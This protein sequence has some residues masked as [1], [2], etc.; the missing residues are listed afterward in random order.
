M[1]K[2]NKSN[3]SM[4]IGT[5]TS[6][7]K[8]TRSET[9]N[10][11]LWHDPFIH[12]IL[13]LFT[14]FAVY[15]NSINVPFMFDD[16]DFLVKNPVIKS[17]DCFP[18]TRKA[19]DFSITPD[20]RNNLV[21]RP[22]T[23]FTFAVN[24]AIHGL[25]LFGYHLVN[26]LLHL[27]CGI[28]VY[29]FFAQIMLL[30]GH[31][32]EEKTGTTDARYLPLFAALLFVCHPIQTQAV[33]YIIQRFV[34][35]ATFFYLAALVLYLEFR[36]APAARIRIWLYISS[37]TAAVLAMESKEIAFTL[38]IIITLIEFMFFRENL[39][40]RIVKLS[41]F[42]VTMAIIPIKLMGLSSHEIQEKSERVSDAINLVNFSGISSGDYLMTQFGVI[43]TY[44]RLLFL[45]V[46]QNLDYDYPLHHHFFT[47]EVLLPLALLL[48]IA[49][50][51]CYLLYHAKENRF[52]KIMAFGIFWFFITLS[53]E[54]SI[55]PIE[56][57]I[58]EQRVY[59]PSI[60]FFIFFLAGVAALFKHFTSSSLASSKSATFL[61]LVVIACLSAATIARNMVWQDE[62]AFWNDVVSKSPHKSRAHRWLGGALLRQSKYIVDGANMMDDL[63]VL[64]DGSEQQLL[65][66]INALKEAIRLA[67]KSPLAY[68]QLAEAQMLQK[69]YD[70]ALRTLATSSE[71]QPASPV[72]YAMRGELFEAKKE[73]AQARREYL[74]A[75]KINPSYHVP[76][77]RLADIYA[78]EGNTQDAIRELESVMKSYPA[79][80]VRKKL[81]RLKNR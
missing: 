41:P 48:M 43:A 24:H 10:R 37:L 40:S 22:A 16:Y 7:E 9:D 66:A 73:I 32:G 54:S 72:P 75:I 25:D 70:E 17:F 1:K 26:M 31:T 65:A 77:L 71:L 21:L 49:G 8:Q 52:F 23:Y 38:P 80:E 55:V 67:P 57:L 46:R 18:D 69:D 63:V 30:Q 59:L 13:I 76:H 68:R 79:E 14:G 5:K 3:K 45:P 47:Q 27:G 19:L 81:D 51:G 62:V 78:R 34:P 15:F 44:L 42:I 39:A 64:K 61:L 4:F 2:P 11:S 12:I 36:Q 33:T 58:F 28:L 60:G 20:I 74:A 50:T 53:V 29:C 56:D 35:L 6:R